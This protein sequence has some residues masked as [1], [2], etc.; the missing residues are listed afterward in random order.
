[1]ARP[2]PLTFALALA[3]ALAACGA[4][5][6]EG[7]DAAPPGR[8][9]ASASPR[10]AASAVE[11]PSDAGPA[12]AAVSLDATA[13]DG[14]AS[15]AGSIDGMLRVP[16]GTFRMG[17]DEL[18]EP[19]EH[20]AHDVTLAPFWLDTTEVTNAAYG[21]CVTAGVCRPIDPTNAARHHLDDKTFRGP[22]QPVSGVAWDDAVQYCGFR[23][24]RLPT[25]AE[26][27]R[28]AR[29]DDGRRY[30]WGS[31]PPDPE[32]AVYANKVTSDV[33]THPKGKGPYGHVDLTGNVWEWT[34]D[35]YDPYAYRRASAATG[36]PGSCPEIM[37]AQ[38]ELRR[39]NQK[40]FTGSNPIPTECERVLRG[41]A[42]NYNASGLRATNRVHHPG[43]YRLV[44]AGFRC[45]RD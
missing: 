14:G 31:E 45:A 4:P 13:G 20:P 27:E 40:G 16:G 25:E 44:M 21:E 11:P 34:A 1:M 32:R 10:L 39:T 28:A 36:K 5:H 2:N 30:P 15:D 18:G 3:L 35:E 42:F 33:G 26:W 7:S 22:Q 6:S 12:D 41:G 23:K 9:V 17:A 29:G 8:S 19:D 24:K 38:D 37:A 43:R